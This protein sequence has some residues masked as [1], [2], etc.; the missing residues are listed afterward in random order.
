[1]ATIVHVVGLSYGWMKSDSESLN[2][3]LMTIVKA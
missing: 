1:M 2:N 3:R